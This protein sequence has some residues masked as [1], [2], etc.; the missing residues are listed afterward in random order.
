MKRRIRRFLAV[1]LAIMV[2]FGISGCDLI[3][4][5]TKEPE[6]TTTAPN[7][8]E[9]SNDSATLVNYYNAILDYAESIK[10]GISISRA[11]DVKD[12][13]FMKEGQEDSGKEYD[14]LNTAMTQAVKKILSEKKDFE[15]DPSSAVYNGEFEKI[16]YDVSIDD[17]SSIPEAKIETEGDKYKVTLN[18]ADLATYPAPAGSTIAKLFKML[19]IE[20]ILAEFDKT[21]TYLLVGEKDDIKIAY[22]ECT[23]YFEANRV[24]DKVMNIT[25][26]KNAFVTAPMTGV[27]SLEKY[28]NVLMNFKLVD[29]TKYTFDWVDPNA[30]TATSTEAKK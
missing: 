3:D 13:K 21:K 15:F 17:I 5:L 10:P 14:V 6:T 12:I 11:L 7:K 23:I 19:D 4:N 28:G 24:E 29:T 1:V 8:T 22:K 25:L 20:K 27:G 26:T 2:L 16:Y 18:I 30:T 9:L